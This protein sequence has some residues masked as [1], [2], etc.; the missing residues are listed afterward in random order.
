MMEI[1]INYVKERRNS[2]GRYNRWGSSRMDCV[3][4]RI[5]CRKGSKIVMLDKDKRTQGLFSKY[6]TR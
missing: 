6:L 4:P 3:K 2:H 1:L 5:D